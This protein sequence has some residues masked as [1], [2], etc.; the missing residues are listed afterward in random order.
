MRIS[1][2]FGGINSYDS[3]PM[4]G[5]K[6]IRD[7]REGFGWTQTVLAIKAG[8]SQALVQ[9]F[10]TGRRIPERPRIRLIVQALG[11]TLDDYDA[12]SA[13]YHPDDLIQ[14]LTNSTGELPPKISAAGLKKRL[15]SARVITAEEL[16]KM[17]K[18]EA[19]TDSKKERE[20]GEK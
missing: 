7:W 4:D 20:K 17:A 2:N 6:L 9:Q 11:K 15:G 8:V 19:Y 3:A 13:K 1:A 16:L 12:A 18:A 14:S 10:E 5:G